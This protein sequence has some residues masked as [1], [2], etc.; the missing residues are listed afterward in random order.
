MALEAGIRRC[1]LASLSMAPLCP[2]PRSPYF[3]KRVKLSSSRKVDINLVNDISRGI[4][5]VPSSILA[6]HRT[7]MAVAQAEPGN[8]EEGKTE[9]VGAST[10][11]Q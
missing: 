3:A 10:F 2:C 11:R 5:W 1:N 7:I 8:L 9:E 6:N 4:Y